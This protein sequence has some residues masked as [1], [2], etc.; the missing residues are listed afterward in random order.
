M[1][2]H[3][4]YIVFGFLKCIGYLGQNFLEKIVRIPKK[5]LGRSDS[6]G[7]RYIIVIVYSVIY[8]LVYL[9][10]SKKKDWYI[11]PLVTVRLAARS[12]E[13]P[14]RSPCGHLEVSLHLS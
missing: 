13:A 3:E 4:C 12:P 9:Y 1:N 7:P 2:K 14:L 6:G 10:F 5:Q 8:I 11:Y